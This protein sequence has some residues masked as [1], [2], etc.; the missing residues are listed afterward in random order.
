MKPVYLLL[1]ILLIADISNTQPTNNHSKNTK[2]KEPEMSVT[3]INK[4]AIRKLYE[5]SLNKRNMELLR[6]LVSDDFAGPGGKKGAAAGLK[7][8]SLL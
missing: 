6:D 4:E 5:Q 2:K 1:A 7:S 8:L 3:Q